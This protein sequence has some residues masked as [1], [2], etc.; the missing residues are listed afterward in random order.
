MIGRAAERLRSAGARDEALAEYIGRRRVL[1][2]P[3]EPV[4]RPVGRVWRIGVLLI[5]TEGTAYATGSTTRAID[6]G[7][8]GY[9]SE[10]AR[11]RA[12][13]RAAARR[14]RFPDGET[15]NFGWRR[16]ALDADEFRSGDGPFVL[17]DD[18]P[19]VRWRV[20]RGGTST[21]ELGAYLDDRVSLLIDPPR[22]A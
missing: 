18:V 3:R 8:R 2:V 11:D 21:T 9:T 20:G 7:R 10:S 5:D 22:G 15:V 1:L 17:V 19:M 13:E 6:P 16:L 12:E 14:G 4:M